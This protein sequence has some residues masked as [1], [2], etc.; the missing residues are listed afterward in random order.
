VS[1]ALV[2]LA[3]LLLTISLAIRLDSP[4]PVI[5]RQRRCGFDSRKFVMLK[6]R[7]MTV[8]EDDGQI[9]QAK[10]ADAR[11]TRLGRLLRRTSLDELP[12]LVNVLRGDMSMVGPRPHAVAHDDEYRARIDNYGLRHHVKPGLTGAAQVLGLRG[13]T[14]R[15]W[16]MERRVERDLWHIDNG[17]LTPDLKIIAMTRVA[18][19]RFDAY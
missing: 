7:T 4:G 9:V 2:A 5:F 19:F 12:Q 3:P 16:Q 15:L 8:L 11:V 18:L 6:F 1:A 10:R 17:S 13:E 14:R